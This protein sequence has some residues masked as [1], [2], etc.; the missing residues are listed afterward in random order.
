MTK[1]VGQHKIV[2]GVKLQKSESSLICFIIEEG[3]TNAL[4]VFTSKLAHIGIP[5]SLHKKNVRLRYLIN[6]IQ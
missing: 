6:D 1:S 2:K 4:P 3:S 5:V